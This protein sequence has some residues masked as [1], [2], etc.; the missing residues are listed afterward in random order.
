VLFAD[1]YTYTL[2]G[3]HFTM[4]HTPGE[5]PDHATIWIPELEAVLVGDNYYEYFINNATLRGTMTRPVL[6]YIRAL[7]TAL[8]YNPQFFLMGHG[9]PIIGRQNVRKTVT[10]FRNA[11]RYLHEAAVKGLNEGKDVYTLMQQVSVPPQFGIPEFYGKASWTVRGICE[12][13]VGWFDENPASMYGV[14]VASIYPDIVE[15]SEGSTRIVGRAEE[16]LKGGEFVKVLHLT[17]VVLSQEPENQRALSV[18]LKALDSL[19]ARSRNYI[20]N[21]WLDYGIRRAK[22]KLHAR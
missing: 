6:G 12:E 17:D 7:D 2:G 15:L 13:Y 10:N 22:E 1:N 5:T 9:T 3:V 18:R 16:L 14:P 20:E 21:I 11:L 19:R 8:S 4:V